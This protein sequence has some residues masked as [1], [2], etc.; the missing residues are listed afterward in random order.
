MKHHMYELRWDV[1]PGASPC[2]LAQSCML[3]CVCCV[4]ARELLLL[5]LR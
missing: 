4:W 3:G 2:N 5:L 1:Q